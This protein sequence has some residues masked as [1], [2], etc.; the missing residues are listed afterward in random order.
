MARHGTVTRYNGGCRCGSCRAAIAEYRRLRRARARTTT[1]AISEPRTMPSNASPARRPPAPAFTERAPLPANAPPP[2]SRP[3]RP[4]PSPVYGTDPRR[5]SPQ[6]ITTTTTAPDL[7]SARRL[8]A[9]ATSSP[10]TDPL[11]PRRSLGL[12]SPVPA[13]RIP[14]PDEIRAMIAARY[15]TRAVAATRRADGRQGR[16]PFRYAI[17]DPLASLRRR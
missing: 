7:W 9:P 3:A 4:Q 6:R 2:R 16:E 15:A 11:R 14:D 10:P 8:P 1:T 17:E 5:Q 12:T 13:G